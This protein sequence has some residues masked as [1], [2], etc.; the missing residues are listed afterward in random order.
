[1][2]DRAPMGI[3]TKG[4]LFDWSS[5]DWKNVKKRV[6]NLRQRIYRATQKQQWNKV[7]SLTKL[8][9]RSYSNL[10]LSVRRVTMENQGRKT[11]GIDGQTATTP[12]KR[13]QLVNDMLDHSL[14]QA[15]PARRIYIPKPNGKKRAL[16]IPTVKNRV[17]Q[18]I[19]KNA[20]E[21]SWEARFEANSYGFR[22]GR[23]CH[24]A[25]EQAWI[26][27]QKGKDT[28]ILDADIQAAFDEISHKSIL[29]TVGEIPGRELIKQWLKAG[30]VEAEVLHATS[31]GTPQGSVISPLL[32]NIT[33][34]GIEALL[35]RY[36]TIKTYQCTRKATGETYLKKK[37]LNKYGFVRYADD[38]IVT[39]RSKQDIEAIVPILE[40]WLTERGLKLNPD[41]TQI[42]HIT[43]G[44]KFLGF[45]IRQ[46]GGSCLMVP[47]K[48]KVKQFLGEIRQWLKTHPTVT[49]E[50][51]IA[52]LN[53]IIR[54]WGNYFRHGVSQRVFN[55][56]DHEIFLALWKWAL[57]RHSKRVGKQK[58]KGKDWVRKKYFKSLNGT[59]WTFATTVIDRYGKEKT[60][61][62]CQLSKTPILR[63][64][65][66]KGTASPDDPT[67]V[68]YWQ[69]R[70]TKYGKSY[71]DRTSKYYKVAQNQEWRCPVCN[72]H[73]FNG[74]Q[75]LHTHHRIRIKDGG[76]QRV[77]N[78]IHLHKACHKHIHSGK[79]LQSRRLEPD[80]GKTVKSGS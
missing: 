71:W 43:Q 78:L 29:S 58:G 72:E 15:K 40:Q 10:L 73:L 61:A 9:L 38:M 67:L 45:S 19:V 22:P 44:F 12:T 36:K 17:A 34:D 56:V 8:M 37:K 31:S 50:A 20:L 49:Q 75:Q 46:F 48:E 35:G 25:L 23:G 62:L 66:V 52:H 77:G 57:R 42:V 16:G 51:V 13:V 24:D 26:R 47:H 80:D 68:Q 65:K 64:V 54:G 21:P 60:I 63:H 55:Y 59:K 3:G 18:A 30:Y 32:A 7:Q 76:T 4:Q 53:P 69:Q 14:W 1:M 27:L 28:W 70:H 39:A 6:R 41:K 79:H 74:E 2:K 11:A 5:I 33:L